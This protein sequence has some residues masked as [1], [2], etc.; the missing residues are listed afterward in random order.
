MSLAHDLPE[1]DGLLT[2]ARRG[3]ATALVTDDR[4]IS[5]AELDAMVTRRLEVLGTSRRLIM[6]ECGNAVEPLATYL[7]A[8]R[9]HH[10]V[11]LVPDL[12]AVAARRQWE[13][14]AAEYRPDLVCSRLGD[15]WVDDE[16]RTTTTHDLH[17][18]L[19]VLLGTSGSTGTPKLVRLSREN[20][21]SNAAAIA[22]YLGLDET[23]RAATTLPMQYCYGLSVVNSHLQ[24]GGSL[25]LTEQSV[26]EP[27]FLDSFERAGAT[28]LAGVPYTFEL[29]ER[30]GQDWLAVAG[31]RQVTQ[32]GGRLAPAVVR[33]LALR[34]AARDV[35]LV[36]M[37]GQTEATARM[38]YLPAGMAAQRPDCIGVPIAG[39]EFRID[40]GELVY[41][42]PNVM[43][44]Y[45]RT[46]ADLALGATLTEL[47]TGD[48]AVQHD[49]GLFEIVGRCNRVAKLFGV[50]LDLDHAEHQL[51][52]GG[53]RASLVVEGD[54]LH[55][56]ATD[57]EDL[58]TARA[59]ISSSHCVPAHAVHGHVLDEVPRT[60]HG[61]TDLAALGALARR[62]PAS[63]A[64]E[65]VASAYAGVFGRDV[66][67]DDSFLSLRGDS[68][69]YVETFARL[70]RLLG[71]VPANWPELTVAELSVTATR[72]R[73]AWAWLETPMVLRALAILLVVGSHV[74]LWK[75]QGGAHVLLAIFGFN[76]TRFALARTDAAER[77]TSTLRAL[78]EMLLPAVVVI[79]GVILVRG[80][81]DW[82]TALMLNFLLGERSWDA[83][84]Q[85]WFLETATWTALG[86]AAALCLPGVRNLHRRRPFEVALAAVAVGVALRIAPHHDPGAV[87]LYSPAASAWCVLLGVLAAYADTWPK[88]AVA[89]LVTT[90]ATLG[91][92]DVPLRGY[93]VIGTVVAILALPR[94]PVPRP[95]DR[96]VGVIASASM[97]IFVTHWQV[98]PEIE[99]AGHRVWA[100]LASVAV[101]IASWWLWTQGRRTLRARADGFR[102]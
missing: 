54:R 89:A 20:L 99:D 70:E 87:A 62:A 29:L 75:T 78:R 24:A 65:D 100:L 72:P 66:S 67:D 35:E 34:A 22:D 26:V 60:A 37:Y 44:G 13:Q 45:A 50:R 49:D 85:L 8:L 71:T 76:L 39:G 31:L 15:H 97:F 16:I 77:L 68:L 52:A 80:S 58:D 17:P 48:L 74:D 93:L 27:D 41:S 63:A 12:S 23:S 91:F 95:L 98:Y 33:D 1:P 79:V 25:W 102:R 47:R 96:L 61:K 73:R 11:L 43:L 84:W 81:Y 69:S 4:V 40:H 86:L 21:R 64:P 56:F 36:V 55:V 42:G 90:A 57:P 2:L 6:L 18:D 46:A 9:G 14:L 5:H 94:L 101:G 3:T 38:A 92:F 51:A 32:A 83:D 53:V 7:A 59:E 19:A 10:P 28:S 30:S 82:P 88:K